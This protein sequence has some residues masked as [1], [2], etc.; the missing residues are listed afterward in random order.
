MASRRDAVF[1]LVR[2][3]FEHVLG[4]VSEEVSSPEV[5]VEVVSL[6]ADDRIE[7]ILSAGASSLTHASDSEIWTDETDSGQAAKSARRLA[8]K[9]GACNEVLV[10]TNVQVGC[11]AV[12][13]WICKTELSAD[14][15]PLC[16]QESTVTL[17]RVRSSWSRTQLV[18]R[19][20][21]PP[22]HIFV[23]GALILVFDSET[24]G[25]CSMEDILVRELNSFVRH[26]LFPAITVSLRTSSDLV[27]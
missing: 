25:D 17:L 2:D 21:L 10:V 19:Q 11:F 26:L 16:V 6:P 22:Q 3:A 27:R 12:L 18:T 24:E 23:K 1:A 15:E 13:I 4:D 9:H 5:F 7:V 14:D 8:T 20:N